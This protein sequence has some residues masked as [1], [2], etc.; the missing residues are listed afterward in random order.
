MK[1]CNSRKEFIIEQMSVVD[2]DIL[3]NYCG[4]T[5]MSRFIID[6]T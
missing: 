6:G 2:S 3:H 5:Q 4:K 1:H